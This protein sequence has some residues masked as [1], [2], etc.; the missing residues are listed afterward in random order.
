[1]EQAVFR[2]AYDKALAG[3]EEQAI[4]AGLRELD[5]NVFLAE[6]HHIGYMPTGAHSDRN[7]LYRGCEGGRLD[8]DQ[9]GTILGEYRRFKAWPD[10]YDGKEAPDCMTISIV[11]MWTAHESHRLDPKYFLFKQE[12]HTHIRE[13]WVRLPLSAVMEQREEEVRPE[14]APD[15]PVQVMTISQTGEIRPREAG[16]GNNPPEWLGM[17]FQESPSTWFAAHTSDVVFSSIDLWKGCIAVV[18]EQFDGALVTKEFPIYRITDERLDPE[19]L[20]CLLRSRYYQR[21]FRAIT[22][23]HSNRRR[24]QTADFEALEI[25]FPEDR[26]IQ[27]RLI[28]DVLL[29]REHQREAA[30]MLKQSM[31]RFSDMIDGRGD[32]DYEEDYE[33]D[34]GEEG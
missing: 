5:Y 14:Q 4:L 9:S 34:E 8:T 33:V 28:A 27:R 17:Y 19:F 29:A 15:T 30:D 21:A 23:G 18:Q 24:T 7:D 26:K 20:S 6:A 10:V 22:T 13:G 1:M 2:E 11:D 16:K 3:G 12:E 32:E 31:L 25:C